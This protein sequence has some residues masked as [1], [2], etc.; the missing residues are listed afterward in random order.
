MSNRKLDKLQRL[1]QIISEKKALGIFTLLNGV[2][3]HNGT[4]ISEQDKRTIELQ[5]DE[6]I[7]MNI[8]IK[9]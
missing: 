4:P 2:H 5:Y 6:T 8:K 7:T 3:Y 9:Q 1:T